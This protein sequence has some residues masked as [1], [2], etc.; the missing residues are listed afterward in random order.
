[1]MTDTATQ[2]PADIW[3][4]PDLREPPDGWTN[5]ERPMADPAVQPLPPM[6]QQPWTDHELAP[7]K[8]GKK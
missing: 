1:M 2:P 8:K 5:E 4:E 3:R 6:D 7:T